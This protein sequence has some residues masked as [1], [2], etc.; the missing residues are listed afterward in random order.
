MREI[1]Q[2]VIASESEAKQLVQAART[3]ADRLLSRTRLEARG[4]VEQAHREA[5]RETESILAAAE[6]DA[7]REKAERLA[8]AAAEIN[9]RI[10]LDETVANEAVAAAW[11][12]V[13]GFPP[14]NQSSP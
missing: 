11:R 13:C 9:A 12:C 7:A 1:I 10:R 14:P 8:R 5:R 2:K 6:T 4:A 3:E